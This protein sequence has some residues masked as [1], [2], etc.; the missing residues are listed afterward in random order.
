LIFTLLSK[1]TTK[2]SEPDFGILVRVIKKR[3]EALNCICGCR[4]DKG[5]DEMP[6]FTFPDILPV[7]SN[8]TI[9]LPDLQLQELNLQFDEFVHN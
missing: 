1:V 5:I 9:F 4:V 2:F 7:V 6:S 3:E 8:S